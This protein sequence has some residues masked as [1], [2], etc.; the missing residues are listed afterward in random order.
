VLVAD[1]DYPRALVFPYARVSE[2]N[3]SSGPQ[4]GKYEWLLEEVMLRLMS[5]GFSEDDETKLLALMD[6]EADGF[7]DFA[8]RGIARLGKRVARPK[9]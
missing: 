5:L 2:I 3:H 9:S 1:S 7:F 4:F 6:V 8:K